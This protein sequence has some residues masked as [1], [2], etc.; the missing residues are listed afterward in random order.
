MDY[1]ALWFDPPAPLARADVRNPQTGELRNVSMLLD[2]GADVTIVP[3]RIVEE[4]GIAPNPEDIFETVDYSGVIHQ[5]PAVRLELSIL[6]H[7][8]RGLFLVASTDWGIIGRNLLN[9]FVLLLD[10]PQ[11]RWSEYRQ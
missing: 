8:F 1:D 4:L 3:A 11:Q 6:G 10:G 2:T 5:Q 7:T 9:R